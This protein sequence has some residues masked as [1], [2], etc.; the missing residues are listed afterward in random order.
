MAE[1][2][3]RITVTRPASMDDARWGAVMAEEARVAL[4]YRSKG[5]I[6]RIWRVPG[7]SDNVGVWRAHD[8][9]ELHARLSSL[10]AFPYMQVTVE[11]LALHY[12]EE[13]DEDRT[14]R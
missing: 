12:L 11:P 7:R 9:T 6:H 8:A 14:Q 4:S 3:V 13:P 10:P 1:F 2:L 5:I